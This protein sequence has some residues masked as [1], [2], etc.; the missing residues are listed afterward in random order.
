MSTPR[1]HNSSIR[2]RTRADGSNVYDV[3]WRSDGRA[4]S[5]SFHTRRDANTF[6]DVLR[7]AGP[8]AATELIDGPPRTPT[9]SAFAETYLTEETSAAPSTVTRYRGYLRTSIGPS[10]GH[11]PLDEITPTEIR[12]WV[13]RQTMAHAPKT[14][15]NH[16][17]LLSA[18]LNYAVK[19]GIILENPCKGIQLP[20][21]NTREAVFLTRD[22]FWTVYD[23]IPP[24]YK[25]L[26]LTLAYTGLRWSEATA[27][28]PEDIDFTRGTL[29]VSRAWTEGTN[30]KLI[31]GPPK[32]TASNRTLSLPGRLLAELNILAR[33]SHP[34]GL[35][36]RNSKGTAVKNKS[37]R[38][39]VWVRAVRLANGLPALN[40][41]QGPYRNGPWQRDP[42]RFPIHKYPN[43]H[44]L[45][46]SHA[47]WLLTE[48]VEFDIIRARLGH[49]SIKMTIDRY[50]HIDPRRQHHAAQALHDA[51]ATPSST[52]PPKRT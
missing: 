50:G 13:N 43:I 19:N 37:F 11:L 7:L 23:Y 17:A 46:H 32:T 42:A 40:Y 3:R 5:R 38:N 9:L 48:G 47:S 27:L 49:E 21:P 20:D 51:L 44:D 29:T 12:Q 31:L 6:R 41:V 15:R 28:T 45:R 1:P 22:E 8:D 10:L 4:H 52:E 33:I 25:P 26:V 36:F 24:R 34:H 16:H 18:I 30:G 39:K 2:T 35:L 14:V